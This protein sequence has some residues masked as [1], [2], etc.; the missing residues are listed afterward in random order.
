MINL[1][2]LFQNH[3]DAKGISD[4]K[5]KGFSEDHIQRLT[6]NNEGGIF[7]ALIADT[8]AAHNQYF[9]S[10]SSE[11]TNLALQKSRTQSVDSLII[12]FKEEVSRREG[13]V[14][15]LYGKDSATYTEFFPQ[16]ISEYRSASKINI[17]TLISRMIKVATAHA[18][19]VGVEFVKAFT[20]IQASYTTARNT[21]IGKKGEVAADRTNT[22]SARTTLELQLTKNLHFIAYTYPGDGVRCN[23]FFTQSIIQ[24]RQSSA[25]DGLGRLAGLITSV[26]TQ[27]PIAN[28]EVELVDAGIPTVYSNAEGRYR[29][30][31]VSIG[32]YKINVKKPGFKTVETSVEI[33]DDGDTL[34]D[35]EL[36]PA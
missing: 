34:L 12:S 20:D 30:R 35:V 5:L 2:T 11:A 14:K 10:I 17:E 28:V 24:P 18:S 3:F 19:E 13:L 9:G 32:I 29:S 16:G 23:S 26:A 33:I 15:S 4:D 22:K 8:S 36:T 7:S 1:N 21:Q 6:A 27:V 31:N 25:T